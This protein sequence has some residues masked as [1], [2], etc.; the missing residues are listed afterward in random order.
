DVRYEITSVLMD[1][2]P[3]LRVRMSIPADSSGV[4]MLDFPDE[5]WGQK[6][7]YN[8][9][10]P[11][12]LLNVEGVIKKD[13][14]SGRVILMHP[15]EV[16]QLEFEYYLKQ[17]FDGDLSTGRVYRPI[18]DKTYFHLFSHSFFM[19]PKTVG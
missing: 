16:K 8:T 4:T 1:S 13:L 18:I 15:K 10:G 7:L 19:V 9:L 17:D 6:D 5:A 2:L 12:Q 3:Q 11:M 14:D